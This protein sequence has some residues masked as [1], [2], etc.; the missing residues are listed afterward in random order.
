M[1]RYVF[2]I[3]GPGGLESGKWIKM[4]LSTEEVSSLTMELLLC[5]IHERFPGLQG[6]E[7][8]VKYFDGKDSIE[9]AADDLDS[10]IDMIETAQ[11]KRENLKRITLDVNKI[12]FTPPGVDTAK[13]P[14]KRLRSSPSPS[15]NSAAQNAKKKRKLTSPK[16]RCLAEVFD[17]SNEVF[18]AFPRSKSLFYAHLDL[19]C[20]EYSDSIHTRGKGKHTRG[21]GI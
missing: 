14:Q 15:R 5:R 17:S 13:S 9:L 11:Q 8:S 20:K 16:A 2:K 18:R 21:K 7:F 10:F 12:A 19:P 3:K 1:E 6:N 4:F